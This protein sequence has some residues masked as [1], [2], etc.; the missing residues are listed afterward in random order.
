MIFN[1]LFRFNYLAEVS[2]KFFA[3]FHFMG[4]YY[5]GISSNNNLLVNIFISKF[6]PRLRNSEPI[7]LLSDHV[8]YKTIVLTFAIVLSCTVY[9]VVF[10]AQSDIALL[11][12]VVTPQATAY[13]SG[14]S[15]KN[16]QLINRH[17]YDHELDVTPDPKTPAIPSELIPSA[18]AERNIL[19]IFD[20]IFSQIIKDSKLRPYTEIEK[21]KIIFHFLEACKST[22][23]ADYFDYLI[24]AANDP[25][26]PKWDIENLFLAHSFL[27][28]Y[29]IWY[30]IR[31]A[32]NSSTIIVGLFSLALFASSVYYGYGQH[33]ELAQIDQHLESLK[34][35]PE[36]LEQAEQEY[37][38]TIAIARF[39]LGFCLL[40]G[41]LS[42]AFFG[43]LIVDE[44][45]Y[46]SPDTAT[47]A[48]TQVAAELPR[49]VF[50]LTNS[51]I[52]LLNEFATTH[53]R[54][55]R[56]PASNMPADIAAEVAKHNGKIFDAIFKKVPE[57]TGLT[58]EQILQYKTRV[59]IYLWNMAQSTNPSLFWEKMA[60]SSEQFVVATAQLF[61]DNGII[62]LFFPY[63]LKPQKCLCCF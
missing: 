42:L 25:T 63:F 26:W 56:V 16:I 30:Q 47:A 39:K 52:T 23:P 24:L 20:K 49:G 17:F 59:L 1:T 58:A 60:A 51:Q 44:Y 9:T 14:L 4:C 18:E 62:K 61:K 13:F 54:F 6:S 37:K 5:Q 35:V 34:D 53:S 57:V 33:K 8:F 27:T 38:D 29:S 3:C 43:I 10:E 46:S 45:F 48:A 11:Y 19:F 2:N 21:C 28:S 31:S 50:R 36:L 41:A 22:N 55:I 15:N 40:V 32:R 12:F 7:Q